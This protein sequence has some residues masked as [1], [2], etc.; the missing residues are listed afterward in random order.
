RVSHMFETFE[1][2]ADIGLRA[3]AH[4]LEELFT[5]AARGLT[6]LLVEDP[7]AAGTEREATFHLESNRLDDLLFD[8]LN[9]LLYR[10]S[11]GGFVA[12]AYELRV[13]DNALDA[14]V[15]GGPFD[16]TTGRMEV[17]AITYHGLLVENRDG[18]WLAEVI[19]DI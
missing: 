8:W 15:R 17:K 10:F 14:T 11:V 7:E 16:R 12:V 1:H 18:E 19:L 3:R 6:S 5:D 4:T 2:T 13:A 9:E